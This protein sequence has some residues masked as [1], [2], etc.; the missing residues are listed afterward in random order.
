VDARKKT[1]PI[2]FFLSAVL[3]AVPFAPVDTTGAESPEPFA[4]RSKSARLP[5]DGE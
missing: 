5:R 1:S 2:P 4:E 3:S